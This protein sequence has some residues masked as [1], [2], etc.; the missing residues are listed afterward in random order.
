MCRRLLSL[1][2]VL[3]TAFMPCVS[4]FASAENAVSGDGTFLTLTLEDPSTDKPY[5][6][7]RKALDDDETTFVTFN[8]GK[9]LRLSSEQP[10]VSLYVKWE[11]PCQ[12]TLTLP[13][14]TTF[15]GGKDGFIHEYCRLGQ[16]VQSAELTIPDGAMLTDIYAFA[17]AN[18]PDW[19]QL[20]EPPCEKAD[21]LVL[22]THADDEHLWFGGALPYYAGELGY[23]VQ[24]VY[25]T[26]HG[27]T[28]RNHERLNGLW[29]VGVRHY[30]VIGRFPD[31]LATKES[32]DAA[33][34]RFGYDNVVKFQ[35]ENLRRFRP[36]VVIGHDMKG[37][38]GHGAH[39]L[40]AKTLLEAV[41]LT[42]DPS[43]YPASAEK[44]GTCQVQKCYLHLWKKNQ[45]VV[46]W[47][48]M[49]LTRFGGKS[50]LD[51]AKEGFACHQSQLKYY[52]VEKDS[53]KYDCRKF[54]LAY[55]TV[56]EDT[57]GT[58]DLFEHVDWSDKV[59]VEETPE[60]SGQNPDTQPVSPGD[61]GTVSPS[62]TKRGF[63]WGRFLP[64]DAKS[65]L[66]AGVAALMVLATA[67][68]CAMCAGRKR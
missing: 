66:L 8:K 27:E 5:T 30:P 40:N 4:V 62:D 44:Y 46:D 60:P 7:G 13:D 21:L 26:N 32:L 67:G 41:A 52:S 9:T 51:M 63:D 53:V 61:V 33:A 64:S 23:D 28:I 3:L 55:T 25:L 39:K 20:W 1:T 29:T 56:G 34:Y 35:V 43:A 19:V 58:N 6:K 2:A 14:G 16:A 11:T 12:W 17:D 57:E 54:G 38:Y 18:P 65:V 31:V 10:F 24:V 49:A 15:D 68:V 37:E 48:S 47:D 59:Q 50:A 36:R 22:P 45:V 42:D